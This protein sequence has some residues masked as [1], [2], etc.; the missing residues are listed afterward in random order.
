MAGSKARLK[1]LNQ[2]G[3][4]SVDSLPGM[5][6]WTRQE[7]DAG[8]PP[9]WFTQPIEGMRMDFINMEAFYRLGTRVQPV[10]LIEHLPPQIAVEVLLDAVKTLEAFLRQSTNK[11]VA[12][13]REAADQLLS[14]LLEAIKPGRGLLVASFPEIQYVGKGG[15]DSDARRAHFAAI[16]KA[17]RAFELSVIPTLR[18]LPTLLV[19]PKTLGH[20]STALLEDPF[21]ILPDSVRAV[22]PDPALRDFF[23]AMQCFVCGQ[24]TAGSFHLLRAVE[25]VM[26]EYVV[27]LGGTVPS[28]VMWSRLIHAIGATGRAPKRMAGR[29]DRLRDHERNELYH[30]PAHFIEEEECWEL[31]DCAKNALVAMLRH[32]AELKAAA[33]PV[34]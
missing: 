9:L 2:G 6:P 11:D 12:P 31:F 14:V 4:G 26:I 1:D 17:F 19:P 7:W 33:R 3:S 13:C 20:V 15:H 16:T 25:S 28:E 29:L 23:L 32:M 18:G 5:V 30:L 34:S 22:F 8:E 21:G 27:A 24:W 10:T